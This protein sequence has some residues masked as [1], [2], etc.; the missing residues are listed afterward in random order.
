MGKVWLVTGVSR[1]LGRAIAQAVLDAGD[2]LVATARDPRALEE[3]VAPHR[4]R[5][6]AVALDVTRAD[7]ARRAV[8]AAV[9]RFGRVDVLV[10]NAGYA[11]TSAIEDVEER[12]FREQIETN[13]FGVFHVTRAVL[14]AMRNQKAGHVIQISSVGG[15]LGTPGL[16]AYQSAKWAVEGFTEVLA[17]EVGPLGIR[18]TLVEP[19]G[20][21]TDWAGS[22][23]RVDEPSEPYRATV[24]AIAGHA[25]KQATGRG[26]PS[27]AAQAILRVASVPE[28]PLRLLLGT[29]AVFLAELVARQRAADDARWRELSVTTDF[30]GI[31]PF[32]ETEL[33]KALVRGNE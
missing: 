10:N 11:N 25:R 12:D 15:R 8:A 28:P 21:R 29:D 30:A 33:A 17:R 16:G 19:G 3:L 2:R 23:M 14:P 24:G 4:D 7:D 26:D 6:L 32:H 22:S 31:A 5:A 27:K 13:F 20:L 18:C 9:E 1:G